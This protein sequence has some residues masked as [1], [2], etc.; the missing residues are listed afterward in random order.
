MAA[1]SDAGGLAPVGEVSHLASDTKAAVAEILRKVDSNVMGIVQAGDAIEKALRAGGLLYEM[2]INPRQVGWDPINRDGEGGN[3]QEVMLLASDIA[4]IGWS[5]A[6]TSHA[7]C[8]EEEPHKHEVEAF[9]KRLCLESGLAPV[10]PY[11]IR[12]GSLS[13]G[14][15]NMALRAIAASMPSSCPL[16]SEGGCLSLAKLQTRDAEYAHAV[17]QGLHWKVIRWQVRQGFPEALRILQAGH[18]NNQH[19]LPLHRIAPRNHQGKHRA[20]PKAR[21]YICTRVRI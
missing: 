4:F 2:D 19:P 20:M 1:S 14:H 13:C 21:T 12:F 8:C 15:T 5:W 17:T 6:E 18:P 11:S 16:L 10:E 9:N 7:I 3:S